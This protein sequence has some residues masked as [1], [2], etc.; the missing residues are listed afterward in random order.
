MAGKMT[1]GLL[2][3]TSAWMVLA[4]LA[5]AQTTGEGAAQDSK[6]LGTIHLDGTKGYVAGKSRAGT[7]TDTPLEETPASVSVVTEAQIADQGAKSVAQALRYTPGVSAEY[8]GA[9]N[10]SDEVYMR[11]FGY[12]PRYV[13]GLA[14]GGSGQQIDAWA[15][16]SV[17]AVKGPASVLYGQAS[18]GGLIDSTTKKA[19]GRTI[20]HIGMSTGS[21]SRAEARFDFARQI[22]G[23]DLAWRFVGNAAQ[24]DTQEKGLQTR[25]LMLAPSVRWTPDDATS[26]T[27]FAMYQREPDAGY[28]NFREYL[29]TVV[30]TT[31]GYIPADFLVGQADFERSSRTAHSLGFDFEHKLSETLTLRSKGR[32]S[33]GD[34]TQRT[35]VWGSLAADER[36]ISRSVTESY[37]ETRQATL[38]NQAE[39]KFRTGAAEHTLLAGFDVQYTRGRSSGTSGAA[40][41][42]I[43]WTNPGAS[44]IGTIGAPR[45]T[46]DSTSHTRQHGLYLQ[47]QIA[48]NGLNVQAGL[49]YDWATSV[50]QNNISGNRTHIDSEALSG[51]LGALYDWGN[52]FATYASYSTSFEPVNQVPQAGESAFDPTE[53]KQLEVGVKWANSDDSL[54]ATL[55]VYDLR[56]TNVMKSVPGTSP[57]RYEQ[58]GEIRSRGVELEV[59]GQVTEAFSMIGSYSYNDSR[60]SKSNNAAEVGLHNDRVPMHQAALWGKYSFESGWDLALGLRYMGTSFDRTNQWNAPAVTLVDLAVGYDLGRFDSRYDGMRAQL[61]VTNLTDE[62]YTASCASRFACFVGNERNVTLALD[63]Q[64]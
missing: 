31:Y 4:P 17:A 1:Q 57:A 11:G 50:S 43:D 54:T 14:F 48:W 33:Q 62:F 51:R 52:G 59:Q 3:A 60:I 12:A 53:G 45:N 13:D 15:L 6:S 42:P 63:Y 46:N 16:E 8:R 30:P 34:W 2:L 23:T 9:S 39:L 64:W 25:R 20:N 36:T 40:V 24:A 22:E 37:S 56:Q 47:D 32:I 26:L 19:D 49:R 5:Q 28:R 29:G 35:L 7:K 18:P 61:N 41:N 27:V 58:V 38:D 21:H 55:S 44:T 10:I